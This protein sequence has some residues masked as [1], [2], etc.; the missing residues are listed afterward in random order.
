M[1]E[2][3]SFKRQGTHAFRWHVQVAGG[4]PED[5]EMEQVGRFALSNKRLCVLS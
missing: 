3:T 1:C 5:E 2:S 4:W